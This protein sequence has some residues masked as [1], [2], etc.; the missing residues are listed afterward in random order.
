MPLGANKAAIMGVAG[1]SAGADVVLLSSQTASDSSSLDFTSGITSTYGEY[2]F[3]FYNIHPESDDVYFGFQV[4]ASG[5]SGYN[6]IITSATFRAYHFEDDSS[7][8]LEYQTGSDQAQSTVL[9]C[10]AFSMDSTLAH[11]NMAGELHLFNPSGTTFTKNFIGQTN[12][13]TN[14]VRSE[15]Q[16]TGGYINVT[17]AITNIQFKMS[18]GNF[19]GKIKMWGVK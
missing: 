17:A 6:E 18:S 10:L 5:Q 1:T 3:E 13:K 4:N 8:L 15:T 7:T 14:N 9:Q 2:I 12:D 11:S 16:F 19:N